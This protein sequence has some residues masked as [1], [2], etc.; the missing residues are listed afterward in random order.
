[1]KKGK[2]LQRVQAEIE[3]KKGSTVG[4]LTR[5]ESQREKQKKTGSAHVRIQ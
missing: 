5:V 2:Y 3:S 1:M 4:E